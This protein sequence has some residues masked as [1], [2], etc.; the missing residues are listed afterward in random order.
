[1]GKD[2]KVNEYGEIVK[3][4]PL[5]AICVRNL[6][7]F[8]DDKVSSYCKAC[9]KCNQM[10]ILYNRGYFQCPACK[11]INATCFGIG[12]ECADLIKFG[13]ICES[14]SIGMPLCKKCDKELDSV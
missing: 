2:Y 3:E 11:E 8:F 7:P 1:M 13:D 10:L 4:G 6:G 5:N 12:D 9:P 14:E